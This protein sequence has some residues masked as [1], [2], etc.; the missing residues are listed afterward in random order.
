MQISLIRFVAA[1]ADKGRP[2]AKM[3]GGS[4][5]SAPFGDRF[6]GLLRDEGSRI[7]RGAPHRGQTRRAFGKEI[8][9]HRQ[10]R[11]LRRFR[12]VR[13]SGR[14]LAQSFRPQTRNANA[15]ENRHARR[16]P[17]QNAN[18]GMARLR[19][20]KIRRSLPLKLTITRFPKIGLSCLSDISANSVFNIRSPT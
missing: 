19:R 3:R 11:R 7:Q 10:A 20:I 9:P 5:R 6:G 1:S 16:E 4:L 12:P 13:Q 18:S 17:N 8:D 2:S 15:R 14:R